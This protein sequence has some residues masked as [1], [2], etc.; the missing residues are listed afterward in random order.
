MRASILF[1][2]QIAEELI[3]SPNPVKTQVRSSQR[4]DG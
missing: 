2:R 4:E 1:Y 3:V